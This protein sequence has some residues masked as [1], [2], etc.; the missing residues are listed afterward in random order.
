MKLEQGNYNCEIIDHELTT[1]KNGNPQIVWKL[2]ILERVHADGTLEA[3]LGEEHRRAWWGLTDKSIGWVSK[4]LAHLGFGGELQQL[5]R[6]DE[7]HVDMTGTIRQWYNSGGD[8]EYGDWGLQAPRE[9]RAPQ[10]I[11]DDTKRQIGV[12]FGA[13]LKAAQEKAGITATTATAA[14]DSP[15]TDD[16]GAPF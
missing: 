11:D 5:D 14:Q 8:S 2:R 3:V 13:E 16:D 1:S 15:A 10:A 9:S 6:N 4:C 7:N 12:L